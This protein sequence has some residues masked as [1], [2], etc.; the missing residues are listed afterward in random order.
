MISTV[1]FFTAFWILMFFSLF[2]LIPLLFLYIPGLSGAR[3]AYVL[4]VTRFWARYVLFSAGAKIEIRGFENLPEDKNICVVS[5]HQSYFDIPVIMASLP[6]IIGFVA[7]KELRSVPFINIWMKQIGCIFLDRKDP[8][9]ALEMFELG[10]RQIRRGQAKL[11]FP[12]GT[13]SRGGAMGPIR[14]GALKLA[15]RGEA[16]IVPVTL[17]GTY[18]F[19]EEKGKISSGTAVM[20]I[21]PPMPTEGLS[22]EQQKELTDKIAARIASALPEE[23]GKE[24]K[25]SA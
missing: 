19:F 5:N 11:I 6:M 13:R 3:K 4:G 20:T 17:N 23:E 22:R 1:L 25:G 21:H 16:I 24:P 18:R 9:Q 2:L 15:F 10:S 12:E 8:R 14:H 7:K